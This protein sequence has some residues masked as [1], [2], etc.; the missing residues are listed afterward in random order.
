MRRDQ[1]LDQRR[2]S[3]SKMPDCMQAMVLV[4]ITLSVRPIGTLGSFA[5]AWRPTPGATN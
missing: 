4:P 5:A 2:H 1:A 3:P